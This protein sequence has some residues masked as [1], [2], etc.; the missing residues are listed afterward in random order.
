MHIPYNC[1]S[2]RYR[3]DRCGIGCRSRQ[4][5]SIP[6]AERAQIRDDDVVEKLY[7]KN[8]PG[9]AYSF[10]HPGIF[11][12]GCWIPG[13]MIVPKDDRG[14]AKN[15][16][17]FENLPGRR[18]ARGERPIDTVSRPITTFLVLSMTDTASLACAKQDA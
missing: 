12:A 3:A 4:P 2:F 11:V 9:L 6:E 17:R 13:W 8:F 1:L 18:Q 10:S 15:Y 14:R 16:G 5:A 7:A